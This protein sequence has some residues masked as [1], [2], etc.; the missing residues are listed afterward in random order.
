MYC[1][2][3]IYC[4][5]EEYQFEELRAVRWCQRQEKMKQE[6]AAQEV[7][8]LLTLHE[9]NTLQQGSVHFHSIFFQ[10]V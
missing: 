9:C 2:D 8:G 7:Q 1:K 4:G 10:P 6:K 5:V 3:K